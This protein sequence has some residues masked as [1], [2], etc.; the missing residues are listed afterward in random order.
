MVCGD[1]HVLE[2]GA[3]GGVEAAGAEGVEEG[4]GGEGGGSFSQVRMS[5]IA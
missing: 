1:L 3:A 4:R 5:G 2:G